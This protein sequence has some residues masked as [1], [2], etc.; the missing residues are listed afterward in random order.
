MLMVTFIN[1]IE[2]AIILISDH[3]PKSGDI[4]RISLTASRNLITGLSLKLYEGNFWCS[5]I[6]MLMKAV[7]EAF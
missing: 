1:F 2:A 6:V 5:I 7:K 3:Q 4:L